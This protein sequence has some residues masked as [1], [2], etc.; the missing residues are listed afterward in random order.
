MKK[1]ILIFII[2]YLLINILLTGWMKISLSKYKDKMNLSIKELKTE[3]KDEM[4]L[5]NDSFVFFPYKIKLLYPADI[6]LSLKDNAKKISLFDK[7]GKLY[8]SYLNLSE[9]DS[10]LCELLMKDRKGTKAYIYKKF[11]NIAENHNDF[12]LFKNLYSVKF[13]DLSLIDHFHRSVATIVKLILKYQFIPKLAG[14]ENLFFIQNSDRD[15]LI[16]EDSVNYTVHIFQRKAEA[17]IF[18]FSKEYI[19]LNKLTILLSNLEYLSQENL[20]KACEKY[21]RE[22]ENYQETENLF[23]AELLLSLAIINDLK[24]DDNQVSK[25]KVLLNK[26]GKDTKTIDK[27]N[28]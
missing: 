3:A 14:V 22:S 26:M 5:P 20:I 18:T 24:G 19:S 7:D 4:Q 25:L 6:S 1:F 15:C 28:I 8:F 11:L 23:K 12:D 10:A 13:S 17:V 27:A 21:Q 9:N 2:L 16:Y